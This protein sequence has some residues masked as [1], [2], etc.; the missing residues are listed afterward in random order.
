M[1][2]G[3]GSGRPEAGAVRGL[4]AVNA[5]VL[6]LEVP[7]LAGR[8]MTALLSVGVLV[9]EPGIGKTVPLSA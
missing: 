4:V 6:R 9:L 1:V 3:V 7:V 8:L 2:I 5:K